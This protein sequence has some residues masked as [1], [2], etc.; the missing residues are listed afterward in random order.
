MGASLALQQIIN[1]FNK[2]SYIVRNAKDTDKA[3]NK[4]YNYMI[5]ENIQH[6]FINKTDVLEMVKNK[7]YSSFR[8]SHKK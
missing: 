6:N 1:K 2:K 8:S 7:Q 5:Q 3:L 4:A